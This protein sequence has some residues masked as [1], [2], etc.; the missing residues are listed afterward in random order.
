MA[1]TGTS[2]RTHYAS[3]MVTSRTL[4]SR[5]RRSGRTFKR[6]ARFQQ[7]VKRYRKNKKLAGALASLAETKL[8]L[9]NPVEESPPIPIQTG[10]LC[11]YKGFVV[12]VKPSSWD[13]NLIELGGI[14][15][16]LG[17]NGVAERVGNYVYYKK[18]HLTLQV[19]MNFITTPRPPVEFRCVVLKARQAVMPSGFTD[20]PQATMF[21]N[22][23]GSP[24]GYQTSGV[25]GM[26]IMN[27]PLNKRDWVI[28]KDFHFNL[29]HPMRSDSDGGNVG[30]TGKYANR[31][32]F[33]LNLPFYKKTRINSSSNKPEDLDTHF[34]VYIFASAIGKDMGADLW[35][36]S[37]RGT[38][39][40]NDI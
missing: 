3:G 5:K 40:Y 12:D 17:V 34:L 35:E 1:G 4:S 39:S 37:L 7:S 8:I 6:P 20:N 14:Q 25:T 32:T 24:I 16:A 22:Q 27:N 13:S 10:A 38:T 33:H 21:L 19:D 28:Y 9:V 23:V 26:D 29:S 31:K 30:Y 11:Q 15:T 2:A 18:T 36:T